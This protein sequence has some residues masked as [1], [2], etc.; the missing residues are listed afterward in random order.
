M[1]EKHECIPVH[2]N[3]KIINIDKNIASLIYELNNVGLKTI[4][5]CE[6]ELHP[7]LEFDFAHISIRMDNAHFIYDPRDNVICIRWNKSKTNVPI[8]KSLIVV[9]DNHQKYAE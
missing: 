1:V 9:D 6:G 2:I 7:K 4:A 5:C 8:P 3:G